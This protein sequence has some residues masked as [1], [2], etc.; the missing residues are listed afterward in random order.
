MFLKDAVK[1]RILK[2]CD[3]FNLSINGL[4]LLSGIPQSTLNSIL[5]GS[6]KNPKIL[7]IL[8][9]CFGLNIELKDFFNDKVFSSLNDD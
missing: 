7:T 1:L 5:D 2:L 9:L 4:A 6:S 8:R 3:E